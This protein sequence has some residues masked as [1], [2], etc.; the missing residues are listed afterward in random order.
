LA[1]FRLFEAA[2]QS[3][4][5]SHEVRHRFWT[6]PPLWEISAASVRSAKPRIRAGLSESGFSARQPLLSASMDPTRLPFP[7]TRDDQLRQPS[8]VPTSRTDRRLWQSS[9]PTLSG[10]PPGRFAE[11]KLPTPPCRPQWPRRNGAVGPRPGAL[12]FR[13]AGI[14]QSIKPSTA[15]AG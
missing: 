3:D 9:V 6:V 13:A 11:L 4:I 7:I 15:M 8:D 10:G 2:M 12:T 5:D 1:I 14:H